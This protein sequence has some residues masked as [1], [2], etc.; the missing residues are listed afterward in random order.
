MTE[1]QEMIK[2]ARIQSRINRQTITFWEK[3]TVTFPD[4][5]PC[6]ATQVVAIVS[7]PCIRN[8]QEFTHH[9]PIMDGAAII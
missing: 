3:A 7:I 9:E 2:M 6:K 4:F 1:Q 8:M 5:D